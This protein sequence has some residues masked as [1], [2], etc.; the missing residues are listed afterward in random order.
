[1]VYQ[2]INLLIY[3]FIDSSIA[4]V[5]YP[6]PVRSAAIALPMLS[7]PQQR[8]LKP[9]VL[10]SEGGLRMLN[11]LDEVLRP[12]AVVGGRGLEIPFHTFRLYTH[13]CELSYLFLL[14]SYV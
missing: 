4:V 14:N 3:Q 13:I 12:V 5:L 2:F 10:A 8:R 6:P 1:M 11:A 7:A 9:T